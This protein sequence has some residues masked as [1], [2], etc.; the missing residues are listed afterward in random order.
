M[1]LAVPIHL[2]HHDFQEPGESG[3]EAQEGQATVSRAPHPLRGEIDASGV[4]TPAHTLGAGFTAGDG[5]CGNQRR[6]TRMWE[7]M[8]R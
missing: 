3:L 2:K 6:L 4:C 8:M 7:M 1:L 5:G